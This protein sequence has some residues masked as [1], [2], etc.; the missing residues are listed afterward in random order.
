LKILIDC[1]HS[2]RF[3]VKNGESIFVDLVT[4]PGMIPGSRVYN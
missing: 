3:G 4:V 2:A 1:R